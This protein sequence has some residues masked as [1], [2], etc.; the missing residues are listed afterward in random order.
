MS[1]TFL[2]LRLPHDPDDDPGVVARE[3]A[4]E[5]GA[6]IVRHVGVDPNV[7]VP[8]D[9]PVV[10]LLLKQRNEARAIAD[11]LG[12][13]LAV[14]EDAL[15]LVEAERIALADRFRTGA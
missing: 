3:I 7:T 6:E 14:A 9:H 1:D 2:T 15:E 12:E 4:K 10:Q 8:L 11:E 13:L 5:N